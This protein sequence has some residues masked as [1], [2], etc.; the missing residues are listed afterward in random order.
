MLWNI[1]I[2]EY[3]RYFIYKLSMFHS[4]VTL[5]EGNLCLFLHTRC[6]FALFAAPLTLQQPWTFL[7]MFN[8]DLPLIVVELPRLIDY[9]PHV[10][11]VSWYHHTVTGLHPL[12]TMVMFLTIVFLCERTWNHHGSA[13]LLTHLLNNFWT[14]A[15][16]PPMIL[17]INRLC[18]F[19]KSP[20]HGFPYKHLQQ[21]IDY[22]RLFGLI[23]LD[24]HKHPIGPLV[25]WREKTNPTR[26]SQ[27]VATWED[28]NDGR[29]VYVYQ[30]G[31][32]LKKPASMSNYWFIIRNTLKIHHTIRF[33]CF[34]HVFFLCKHIFHQ[35]WPN[36]L[37]QNLAP[38]PLRW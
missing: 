14:C 31:S 15:V 21:T 34:F 8:D 37:K 35:S 27:Q 7:S 20:I 29:T 30:R 6:K 17:V 10:C 26:P 18:K 22:Y 16:F 28:Y 12:T 23:S 19:N 38:G 36:L 5:P 25:L 1:I 32:Q 11:Y 3:C 13:K 33:R 24:T 4:Y 9:C 2:T